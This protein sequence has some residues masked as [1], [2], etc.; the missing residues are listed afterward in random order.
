M[1]AEK[2]RRESWEKE[3]TQEIKKLTIKGLEPEV[4][5]LLENHRGEKLRLIEKNE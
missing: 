1:T 5:R 2:L 4:E 3:K